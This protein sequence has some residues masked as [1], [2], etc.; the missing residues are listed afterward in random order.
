MAL[1]RTRRPRFHSN[2]SPQ[3]ARLFGADG[4]LLK[5]ENRIEEKIKEPPLPEWVVDRP[6][7]GRE[8]NFLR[9]GD[10]SAESKGSRREVR[11]AEQ[12]TTNFQPPQG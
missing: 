9:F 5:H 11:T 1:Q 8:R 6:P 4:A 2:R 3:N 12:L 7:R 10:K